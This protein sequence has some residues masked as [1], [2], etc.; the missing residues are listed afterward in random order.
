MVTLPRRVL[1]PCGLACDLSLILE[2]AHLRL[3][4][5]LRVSLPSPIHHP[6]LEDRG[7]D[8]AVDERFT[9]VLPT[10]LP[11]RIRSADLDILLVELR[12]LLH[13]YHKLELAASHTL[14][15][16][17]RFVRIFAEPLDEFGILRL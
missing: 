15:L 7:S 9:T 14:K 13:R 10:R 4:C 12:V 16:A 6:L 8:M 2:S 3:S 5:T 11:R 17:F 1:I